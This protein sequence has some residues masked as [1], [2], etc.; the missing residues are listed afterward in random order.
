[1]TW[2][3]DPLGHRWVRRS[4]AWGAVAL[5]LKELRGLGYRTPREALGKWKASHGRQGRSVEVDHARRG[6]SS[7]G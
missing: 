6:G 2:P 3:R 7:F 5:P 4:L 1:M